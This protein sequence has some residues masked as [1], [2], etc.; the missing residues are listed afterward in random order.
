[1]KDLNEV[2]S[3]LSQ[4]SN[5]IERR[6]PRR[7]SRSITSGGKRSRERTLSPQERLQR[8]ETAV[9][10]QVVSLPA[11]TKH[12]RMIPL[13]GLGE[14]GRNMMALEY[15]DDI[16]VID[17][18]L[19]FPEEDMPGIDFI[20]PN[21]KYLE[22]RVDRIRG[23]VFTHGHYDHIG[24]LPYVVEKLGY[25]P[26]YAS[27]LT[28]GILL[29]RQEEF[30]TSKK[31]DITDVRDGDSVKL[32]AFTVNFFHVNHN[33]PDDLALYIETPM[34]YIIHT[35]DF[36]FDPDPVNDK[37]A[38]LNHIKELGDKGVLLLM[39][40]STD[41]EE[42]G[43]SIS[44]RTILENLET[45]FKESD[46]K[47]VAATF[48]SLLNRVQQLIMLAE[49][50]GRKVIVEGYTMT[51]NLEIA[52]ELGYVR[53]PKG[54][55]VPAKDISKYKPEEILI[56]CTGAQG[57]RNAALMR[58]A[59]KEHRFIRLDKGDSIIFS[60]SV[61]PGNE[62]SVQMLKDALF[63]QNVKVYHYKMMDIHAGGHAK[64]ADLR[65]MIELTRPKFFLPVHGQFSMLVNHSWL[66]QEMGVPEENIVVAENGQVLN[67]NKEEFFIT[68]ETV[69]AN[70]V[71]VDGLGVGD[72]G[73]IVLRDR[74]MMAQDGMF[75]VITAVDSRSGKVRGNPDIISRGFVYLR[76]SQEL[77]K[78]VR[79]MVRR[80]VEESTSYEAVDW[81]YVKN[82]IRDDLGQFLFQKTKRRPMVLPVI[83]EV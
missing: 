11:D 65:K 63:R 8:F 20:I 43:T 42:E 49:K 12:I 59:N 38:D 72:V 27:P 81:A 14:V 36:K 78:D 70:Y 3:E 74:Q 29:K 6:R 33:I 58:I 75:V 56:I 30:K 69:P 47:I 32:G 28:R 2:I 34:G 82:N 19:R 41:A 26:L 79:K 17:A 46:K 66:A 18:G 9:Q 61:I 54:L 52:K 24:A 10:Q 22:E 62:R 45:I 55:L 57:E 16:M 25:P 39:S 1:M 44:E 73:Q 7:T 35:S 68:K 37:P 23:I 80:I 4:S 71:M 53:L 5:K 15:G 64:R 40:D 31:V 51:T 76:E 21:T 48:G 13:G 77:L 50:Y 83:I 60:S 67:L